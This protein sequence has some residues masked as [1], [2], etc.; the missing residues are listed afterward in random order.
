MREPRRAGGLGIIRPRYPFLPPFFLSLP[1]FPF[2][3][4]VCAVPAGHRYNWTTRAY[5]PEPRVLFPRDLAEWAQAVSAALAGRAMRPEAGIVN[6]YGPDAHMGGHVDDAELTDEAP[7]VSLSLG[8]D[9]IFLLGGRTRAEPPIPIRV[10]SGDVF[11]MGGASRRAVHGMAS[12]LVNTSP[13]GLFGDEVDEEEAA[14][15]GAGRTG[16]SGRGSSSRSGSGDEVEEGTG[17]ARGDDEATGGHVEWWGPGLG[18]TPPADGDRDR[19]MPRRSTAADRVQ[20]RAYLR[21]HR[22]NVNVRQVF[23]V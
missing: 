3:S 19:Y 13:P 15:G 10:Q 4:H 9:A 1:L 14:G 23:P 5:V 20:M 18:A 11:V 16:R 2:L 22:V 8:C 21:T 6:F 7:I 12:I 17:P